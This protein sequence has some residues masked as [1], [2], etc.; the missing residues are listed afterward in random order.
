MMKRETTVLKK[1]KL[2][3]LKEYNYYCYH[4]YCFATVME[5]FIFRYQ[6]PLLFSFCAPPTP[7]LLIFFSF[8]KSF[9][10]LIFSMKYATSL[11]SNKWDLLFFIRIEAYHAGWRYLSV[12]SSAI[13]IWCN[14]LLFLLFSIISF[15]LFLLCLPS[16]TISIPNFE[17]T[18]VLMNQFKVLS[19]AQFRELE[20]T[21]VKSSGNDGEAFQE[22]VSNC[23]ALTL[24]AN[25]ALMQKV[26]IIRSG[27][28]LDFKSNYIGSGGL[29]AITTLLSKN[30]NFR[31]LYLSGN[32]IGNDAV[33]FFCRSLRSH[34]TLSVID[35]SCND[36]ISLAG[37]LA[38]LSLIQQNRMLKV[39]NL[40][41][42]QVPPPVLVKIERALEKNR[43]A[44]SPAHVG[45]E[46]CVPAPQRVDAQKLRHDSRLD[47]WRL[48]E[49]NQ[50]RKLRVKVPE[51][52]SEGFIPPDAPGSGWR[53][54]E[55]IILA[56]PGIFESERK[57]LFHQVFPQLNEEMKSRR[58]LLM[59]L[60]NAADSPP[61]VYLRQLRFSLSCDL[62][63]DILRSR[64]VSIEL[65]G[66]RAGDYQQL[67]SN[68]LVDAT[69]KGDQ[70][71]T[72]T[73]NGVVDKLVSA[74]TCTILPLRPVIFSAHEEMMKHS[75]WV[76]LSTRRAT[77]HLGVPPSLAPLLSSEPSIA[78]PD[79]HKSLVKTVAVKTT[80]CEPNATTTLTGTTST[81]KSITTARAVVNLE[82]SARIGCSRSVEEM[83]W[84]ELQEFKTRA[85]ATATVPELVVEDYHARFHGTQVSGEIE[86]NE[87]DD[88][89]KS[90]YERLFILLSATF[91]VINEESEDSFSGPIALKKAHRI[92]YFQKCIDRS[93]CSQKAEDGRHKKII[94]NRL[95][96]YVA[97]PPSRNIFC[98]HGKYPD[99]LT[100]LV[101]VCATRHATLSSSYIV[102][103]HST[104]YATVFSEPTD[105]RSVIAHLL[106]QL[107]SNPE[108]LQYIRV[109]V[110]LRRLMRFFSDF[111]SGGSSRRNDQPLPQGFP[112]VTANTVSNTSSNGEGS[113]VNPVLVV[114]LDGLDAIE[115]PVEPCSAL[116]QSD[117]G[118]D[119]WDADL[120]DSWKGHYDGV[121]FIPK[122]LGRYV[123]FIT[124]CCSSSSFLIDRLRI[125]GRDSCDFLDAGESTANDVEVMLCPS[126]LEKFQV[127]LSVDDHALAQRKQD[128][129]NP[130]YMRYLV[131]AVRQQTEEPSFQ[132]KTEMLS[133]FPEN[134]QGAASRV[135]QSLYAAFGQPLTLKA[136]GLLTASRW[137]LLLPDFRA[138]LK[139]SPKRFNEMLRLLRPVVETFSSPE[140]GMESGN[141][142]L[143]VV[144][145]VSPSFLDLLARERAQF[146]EEEADGRVWHSVLAQYYH[147]IILNAFAC[148]KGVLFSLSP[149]S[150]FEA[151]A[152]KEVTYHVTKARMWSIMDTTLLSARFLM[153]VYRNGLAYPFL[154]DL[155]FAFNE[156]NVTRLLAG[157]SRI[158]DHL[159]VKEK[160]RMTKGGVLPQSMMKMKDFVL[161]I[162]AKSTVL[163]QHPHLVLQIALERG[164]GAFQ[165]VF[166]DAQSYV[167]KFHSSQ[168]EQKRCYEFF[169][170]LVEARKKPSLHVGEVSSVSFAYNRKYIVSGGVDR[171]ISWVDPIS[172][173]VVFQLHQPS[174]R[175]L[176]VLHCSTSAYVAVLTIHRGVYIFDGAFGKLVSKNEGEAFTSPVS[177]FCFSAK[178]R[179]YIVATEDL[180]FRVYDSETS[181]LIVTLPPSD[182]VQATHLEGIHQK[183]NTIQALCNLQDDEM[184][185]TIVNAYICVWRVLETRDACCCL[186]SLTASYVCGNPQ[187]CVGPEISSE[188]DSLLQK[189]RYLMCQLDE[190]KLAL[191]DLFNNQTVSFFSFGEDNES[192]AITK[193]VIAPNQKL[194]AAATN[195]GEI[196]IFTLKWESIRRAEE[197]LVAPCSYPDCIIDAFSKTAHPAVSDLAFHST[198]ISLFALGNASHIKF[199]ALPFST[200]ENNEENCSYRS[201]KDKKIISSTSGDYVHSTKLTAMS[202]AKSSSGPGGVEVA[203]G[204]V[205]GNLTLLSMY[206]SGVPDA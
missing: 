60:M 174:S 68:V 118:E 99:V 126:T 57:E 80:F 157:E 168:K 98:L 81:E 166:L 156:R 72:L 164:E 18:A 23:R 113:S 180:Q 59:P 133:S 122:C 173:K 48:H 97:T 202:V 203:L 45:L 135:L 105:L 152:V 107:T 84:E 140:V 27:E 193:Y 50:L 131:D 78:H 82:A 58:I 41:G 138:F 103:M 34:P 195:E 144:R 95:N 40:A 19:P 91:P 151:N 62:I 76:I 69:M 51:I 161:F 125:R 201:T 143:C 77:R 93:F 43:N 75:H 181:K 47:R 14:L 110:D 145:V 189:S 70:T 148:E 89:S 90:I 46:V 115:P 9:D 162:R 61:G 130:E 198:S 160:S 29:Q 4:S 28:V 8:F 53:V 172:G 96:L 16:I 128:S 104:R 35:F 170:Q 158:E 42:T 31:E 190:S 206:C 191:I 26:E 20:T 100:S 177:S 74:I 188:T 87:L 187:W 30:R 132:N 73:S 154:R 176:R 71:L 12:V 63:S 184:F 6:F 119:V 169:F 137:G 117:T 83:K 56:P 163:L 186:A 194:L 142:V 116:R 15:S 10:V 141:A 179:Y 5:P 182:V 37:G 114:V 66:D 108:V 38:L 49:A 146:E 149:S 79:K 33:V 22:F 175:V 111:L 197:G 88:F 196:G 129:G 101:S 109:E 134:V 24:K 3:H 32:G 92:C 155:I 167:K 124:T 65:I 127:H 17:L 36:A 123:R 106:S 94:T 13:L 171:A 102:A 85:L 2:L 136:L 67:P 25:T 1:S 21:N 11:R 139:L 153:L 178:G 147:N 7:P 112:Q 199:W 52:V 185:Y 204:D 39:V 64:F 120:P 205:G 165:G 121:D 44:P 183:R 55:V 86:M 54:L 159:D 200:H 150:P 192:K